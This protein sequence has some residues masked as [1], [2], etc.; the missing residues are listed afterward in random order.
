[1][2]AYTCQFGF[3]HKVCRCPTPHTIVCDRPNGHRADREAM[4]GDGIHTPCYRMSRGLLGKHEFHETHFFWYTSS[5]GGHYLDTDPG[6]D[7]L[8][9]DVRR[10]TCPGRP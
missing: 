5:G 10:W 4:S 2:G 9:R 3:V 7:T 6:P 8:E 1:M